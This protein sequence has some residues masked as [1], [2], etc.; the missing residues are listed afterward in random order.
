MPRG[1]EHDP[2]KIVMRKK[3][4]C[5]VLVKIS[6]NFPRKYISQEHKATLTLYWMDIFGQKPITRGE[7]LPYFAD[8]FIFRHILGH[9]F[10]RK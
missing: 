5:A 4:R 9:F 7:Q 10:P 8:Q 3:G 1:H 2:K 6:L